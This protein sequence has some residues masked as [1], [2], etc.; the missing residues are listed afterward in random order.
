MKRAFLTV[1]ALLLAACLVATGGRAT[2]KRQL[3]VGFVTLAG[4]VP[5]ARTLEGQALAG[6]LRAQ[7]QLGISGRVVYVGP[8][9]DPVRVFT[10]LARQDYDLVISA[11]PFEEPPE[12]AARQFP[13]VRFLIT[14]APG[15]SPHRRKNLERTVYR[16]EQ[17]GYLAGYLAA[18]MEKQTSGKHEISAVGGIPFPGVARWIVGY[19]AGAI[20]ADPSVVVRVDY[21]QNFSNPAKC[22]RVA[23]NQI[24]AG[25]GSIFNVAGVCGLGALSAARAEGVWGVGVDVDQSFLGSHILTSAIMRT[26]KGIFEM[27]RRLVRG[28]FKTGGDSVFDLRGGYVGLGRINKSVPRAFLRRLDRIHDQIVAGKIKVPR[29]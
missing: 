11:I 16:A 19:R 18:L 14:D 9:E 21:S 20:R 6:F 27:L 2:A 24:A 12:A 7:K 5:T 22:K 4:V 8:T 10:G 26:D 1:A 25:S 15:K 23:R 28:T 29:A 3:R 13:N 17:A